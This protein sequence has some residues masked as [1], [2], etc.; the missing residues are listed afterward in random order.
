[1]TVIPLRESHRTPEPIRERALKLFQYLREYTLL[2][3][4]S[5]RTTD[6]YDEVIWLADVPDAPGCRCAA[7]DQS[8][9]DA[10]V[11]ME[12]AQPR[13][14]P[15]PPPP[16]L[17]VPW[18]QRDELGDSSRDVPPLR[19]AIPA[20][21]EPTPP[22]EPQRWTQLSER[23]DVRDL[24][25][26]YVERRWWPWA[27][28][29][30]ALGRQQ[31]VYTD[32]FRLHQSQQRLGEAYEVVLGL[33]HLAWNA[34]SGTAVRRHLIVAQTDVRFDAA[35]GVITVVAASDGARP[36]LEQDMLEPDER[37]P[38]EQLDE[39]RGALAD[40]GDDL[41]SDERLRECLSAWVHAAS[42]TGRYED[43]LERQQ[44]HA[45]SPVVHLAPALILRPRTDRSI[46]QA[47]E[48]ILAKLGPDGAYVPQGV[49]NWWAARP[50]CD[51]KG[52]DRMGTERM[53]RSCSRFRRTRSSATSS[54]G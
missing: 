37:P 24:Y 51:R 13:R 26:D 44:S 30:R 31:S 35:R 20:T 50:I 28:H 46:V 53:R 47:Y 43:V 22:G 48:A 41:F 38:A 34:P 10:E 5:V 3:V 6:S 33:G 40:I 12:V 32:L 54:A 49:S 8:G 2:R 27:E 52:M 36:S 16:S 18:L 7:A 19:D 23:P 39:I 21:D 14:T 4:K 15:P 45:D 17:L 29:D 11:W 25:D 1:M 42:S 9:R